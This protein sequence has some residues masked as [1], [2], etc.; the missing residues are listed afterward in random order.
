MALASRGSGVILGFLIGAFCLAIPAAGRAQSAAISATPPVPPGSPIP[1]ILPPT[2]PPVAPGRAAPAPSTPTAVPNATLRVERVLVE[3]ATAY[4]A[5]RLAPAGLTGP[6]VSLARIEAAREAI[7]ARYRGDGFVLTTVSASVDAAGTLR[8]VVTEGRIVGV[9]LAGDIGPA[10]TQV[11]R[12]LNRLTETR[13]IDAATLERYLLLAQDVPGITLHAVLQPSEEPGALTLIA[14][15]S[16]KPLSGLVTADNRAS[17]FTGPIEGIG[18]LDLNSFTQFGER[19]ELSL[20]HAFPNTQTFG[21]ASEEFYIGASGLRLRVYAGTGPAT[22]TGLLALEAYQG[23]TNV[24]GATL[25]YPVIRARQQ[26]LNLFGSLDALQSTVDTTATGVRSVTSFDSLRV[27]R[28]GTDYVR[29][30]L[31]FGADH[32]ASNAVTARIS[33]GLAI[34]GASPNGEANAPRIGR[35]ALPRDLRRLG[36]RSRRGRRIGRGARRPAAVAAVRGAAE[37]TR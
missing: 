2:L 18:V 23:Y 12:F 26:T 32:P 27:A 28:A 4:P 22:P 36:R 13:P 5:S 20:Y 11:L 10:G 7:L 35:S 19:T 31:L 24:A 15:V 33:K 14:E 21:Q 34:L 29:S 8:F 25:T 9:K 30:D 1:R 6:A 3:G 16:R 17:N 37:R